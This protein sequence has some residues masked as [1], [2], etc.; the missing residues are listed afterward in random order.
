[1]RFPVIHLVEQ[2]EQKFHHIRHALKKKEKKR[3]AAMFGLFYS[4]SADLK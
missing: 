3:V 4:K 2:T 1:M